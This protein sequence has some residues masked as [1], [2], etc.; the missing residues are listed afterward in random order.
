MDCRTAISVRSSTDPVN[1]IQFSP[2]RLAIQRLIS[3]N[4]PLQSSFILPLISPCIHISL[5]GVFRA[6]IIEPSVI[7]MRHRINLLVHNRG[8]ISSFGLSRSNQWTLIS[9]SLNYGTTG[10]HIGVCNEC[11][12]NLSE[13]PFPSPTL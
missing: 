5:P 10:C 9:C 2:G 3:P 13:L 12:K 7:L 8:S 1:H 6:T 4:K 11:P